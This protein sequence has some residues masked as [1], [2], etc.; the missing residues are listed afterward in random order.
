[1]KRIGA[2]ISPFVKNLG[3]E[4]AV[5]LEDIRRE[6]PAIFSEPLSMHMQPSSLKD[7]ELIINVDSPVWLQQISF[8]R[9]DIT[10]KLNRFNIKSVRFRLGRLAAPKTSRPYYPP[11]R[12]K[13]M[14][15]ED[16]LFIDDT[17]S[18][19][20]DPGLQE[21]I[22]AVMEKAFTRRMPDKPE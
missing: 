6:W 22:K 16:K 13:E 4:G 11:V 9:D 15:N 12:K 17:V 3:I 19:V 8:F 1:M 18:E 5:R 20:A 2:L 14:S 21:R 7:N 10:G